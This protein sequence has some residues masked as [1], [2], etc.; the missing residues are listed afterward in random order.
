[1]TSNFNVTTSRSFKPS[2]RPVVFS[3]LLVRQKTSLL[4]EQKARIMLAKQ[5][6]ATFT[7]AEFRALWLRG[8][9]IAT[10]SAQLNRTSSQLTTLARNYNLPT[11]AQV[12]VAVREQRELEQQFSDPSPEEIA[13]RAAIIRNNWTPEEAN[14]RIVGYVCSGWSAPSYT[15]STSQGAFQSACG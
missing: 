10:L 7:A 3:R 5:Q 4:T 8:A 6:P 15:Y 14:A 9:P 2:P 1:M 13:A 12:C 11:R